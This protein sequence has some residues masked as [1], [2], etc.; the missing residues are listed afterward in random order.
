MP[1]A[2]DG[3]EPALP[4]WKA[5]I[6]PLNYTRRINACYCITRVGTC[7]A[8]FDIFQ[9]HCSIAFAGRRKNFLV[10]GQLNVQFLHRIHHPV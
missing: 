2:G 4:A 3:I 8:F 6:L 10:V 1:G 5:G 7:Q 9:R